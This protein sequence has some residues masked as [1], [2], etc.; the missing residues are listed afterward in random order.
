MLG[1]LFPLLF[2]TLALARALPRAL[3]ANAISPSTRDVSATGL[4]IRAPAFPVVPENGSNDQESTIVAVEDRQLTTLWT[5]TGLAQPPTTSDHAD[6]AV[7]DDVSGITAWT[8]RGEVDI[9][10]WAK[11]GDEDGNND[12][13]TEAWV[14]R[15]DFK[16]EAWAK[17]D[18]LKADAWAKVKSDSQS[19]GKRGS[20]G[21]NEIGIEAWAKRDGSQE[22]TGEVGLDAWARDVKEEEEIVDIFHPY[23]EVSGDA[24]RSDR[25]DPK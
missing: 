6:E 2:V 12:I 5:G 11:R 1:K 18:G 14:K 13:E 17:R 25:A 9:E 3:N 22:E 20:H 4:M 8:K 16:V 23:V 10:A 7:E 15:D 24:M 19:W 21:I